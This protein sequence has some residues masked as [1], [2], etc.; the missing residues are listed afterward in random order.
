MPTMFTVSSA[1]GRGDRDEGHNRPR[2]PGQE[3][4]DQ[5]P[6]PSRRAA[7]MFRPRQRSCPAHCHRLRVGFV[8]PGDPETQPEGKP[9]GHS[10]IF[11]LL[12]IR[13]MTRDSPR[14]VT[15][16]PQE[17]LT[18]DFVPPASRCQLVGGRR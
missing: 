8:T 16:P 2:V 13:Q 5:G 3:G 17:V 10:A 18:L 6:V 15:N 1:P 11:L 14:L 9:K 12:Q 4:E 7:P